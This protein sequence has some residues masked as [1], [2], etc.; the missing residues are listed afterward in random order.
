MIT[1]IVLSSEFMTSPIFKYEK[2]DQVLKRLGFAERKASGPVDITSLPISDALKESISRWDQQ[3]QDTF[4]NNYPPDSGFVSP[5]LRA[6]HI[7]QGVQLAQW[8]Q[9]ELGKDYHVAFKA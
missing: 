6:A 8:L 5:N 7:N 1:K 3:F 4:D 9:Q 2:E